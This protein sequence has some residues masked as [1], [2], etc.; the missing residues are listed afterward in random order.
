MKLCSFWCCFI[1]SVPF[2]EWSPSLLCEEVAPGSQQPQKDESFSFAVGEAMLENHSLHRYCCMRLWGEDSQHDVRPCH[3][4]SL[5]Q[6]F[7]LYRWAISSTANRVNLIS[8]EFCDRHFFSPK[9]AQEICLKLRI[10]MSSFSPTPLPYF[11]S[12]SKSFHILC[13]MTALLQIQIF[14]NISLFSLKHCLWVHSRFI[15]SL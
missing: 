3:S 12:L 6:A 11:I 13:P 9:S 4:C 5:C 8:W 1:A 14:F 7:L 15:C 10:E 2:C